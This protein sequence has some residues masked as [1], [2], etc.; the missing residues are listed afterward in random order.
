MKYCVIL[1][2]LIALIFIAPLT[3]LVSTVSNERQAISACLGTIVPI[4]EN[5]LL[6]SVIFAVSKWTLLELPAEFGIKCSV[7]QDI[8]AQIKAEYARTGVSTISS[9]FWK[10]FLNCLLWRQDMEP[11]WNKIELYDNC[12]LHVNLFLLYRIEER[13]GTVIEINKDR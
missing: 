2:V 4:F 11:N 7:Y 12:E 1:G 8:D 6:D 3:P 5:K 9:Q 13:G 10:S